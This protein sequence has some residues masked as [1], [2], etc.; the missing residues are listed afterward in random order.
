[1][2]ENKAFWYNYRTKQFEECSPATYEDYIPQH[3]AA[4]GLYQVLVMQGK[5]PLE[6]A[7]HVL[8]ACIRAAEGK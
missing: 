3:A 5:T 1:M 8:E 2:N 4:Q 6:A 7:A